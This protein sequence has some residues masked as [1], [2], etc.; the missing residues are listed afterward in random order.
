MARLRTAATRTLLA[1]LVASVVPGL[2]TGLAADAADAA[3]AS[4]VSVSGTLLVA[5]AERDGDAPAYAVQTDDGALVE[6]TGSALARRA[7]R[8]PLHRPT[9]RSRPPCGRTSGTTVA[10]TRPSGST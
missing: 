9:G 2:V 6:V 3:A 10:S 8:L 7:A 1:C 4:E 5:P